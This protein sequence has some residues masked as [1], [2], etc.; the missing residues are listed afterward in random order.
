MTK[1]TFCILAALLVLAMA[2]TSFVS[3]QDT[4]RIIAPVMTHRAD[5]SE[6]A[7]E[8]SGEGTSSSTVQSPI[9]HYSVVLYGKDQVS[10]NLV[11]Y[12]HCY[13]QG[14]NVATCEFYKDG[15]AL[16]ENRYKGGRIGLTYHWS[17][18]DAVLDLLRN[19]SPVF[20]AFIESTKVG[21][22]ATGTSTSSH[23]REPVGD[24][25]TTVY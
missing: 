24:G 18:F 21:Y 2:T 1:R 20:A 19:E 9:D 13:Y 16:P 22:I 3:S 14:K 11:A 10:G 12:I 6:S 15:T 25:E 23:G 4:K 8:T 7:L 5:L 17:H